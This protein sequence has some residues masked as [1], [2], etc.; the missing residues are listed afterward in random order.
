[1]VV[2][3]MQPYLFPYLGYWQLL[4]AADH[5]VLLDD[6]HY[7]NRGWINRNRIM[8]GGQEQWMTIPLSR[9]SQNREIREIELAPFPDWHPAVQRTLAHAYARA[10]YRKQVQALLGEIFD[11]GHSSL[12]SLLE[13]SIRVLAAHL[14]LNTIIS[15]ASESHPKV[16]LR[17]S[18]RILDVCR[19]L[20]ATTYLNLP[21]GR[22]L[23]DPEAFLREGIDLRF[24]QTEWATLAL[25]G[26]PREHGLS[27]LHLLMWNAAD[28]VAS[29]LGHRSLVP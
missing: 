26:E 16:G 21:G 24:I 8:I 20:G 2:A 11:P 9:A 23:Y 22:E 15:R 19:R 3:C 10:P 18:T 5:F 27:I 6:V 25:A 29:A 12:V 1:M 17:G 4:A 14:G 28:D 13:H 7:I